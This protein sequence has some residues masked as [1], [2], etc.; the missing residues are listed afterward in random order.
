MLS[1]MQDKR[2]RKEQHLI[3]E[4]E[5]YETV[6]LY[7]DERSSV[8]LLCWGSTKGACVETAEKFGLRVVQPIVLS[9]FPI[10]QFRERLKGVKKVISVE[11]NSTGQLVRLINQHG[12][13]VDEKILKY[14]GR[15]FSLEKLE[16]D[17]KKVIK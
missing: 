12:F 9:P 1:I 14:D 4:L 5:K 6:K 13:N 17:L 3:Q 8:A 15:P 11:N 7:G 10:K 2:L 16:A